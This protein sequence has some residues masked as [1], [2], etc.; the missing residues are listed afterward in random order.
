MGKRG[1]RS[2]HLRPLLSTFLGS[3]LVRRFRIQTA[4]VLRGRAI[5]AQ[6]EHI[7]ETYYLI[8]SDTHNKLLTLSESTADTTSFVAFELTIN[9]NAM[10]MVRQ[11]RQLLAHCLLCVNW[12][13]VHAQQCRPL[14][15]Q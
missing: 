6:V 14:S 2:V 3:D 8:L 1:S 5:A 15:P 4:W 11:C 10:I 12:T 7:L 13:L 9:R